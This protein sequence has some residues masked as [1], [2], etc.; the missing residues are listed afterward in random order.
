[1]LCSKSKSLAPCLPSLEIFLY[2]PRAARVTS[3]PLCLTMIQTQHVRKTRQYYVRFVRYSW[4]ILGRSAAQR[5]SWSFFKPEVIRWLSTP[6]CRLYISTLTLALSFRAVLN[7]GWRPVGIGGSC[8]SMTVQWSRQKAFPLIG[9][10]VQT[11]GSVTA[12]IC[13]TTY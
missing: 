12:G 1:M 3:R 6:W 5:S 11:S 13:S 2:R 10:R 4:L 8:S 7:K 9:V